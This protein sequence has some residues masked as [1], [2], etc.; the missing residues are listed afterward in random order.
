M[1]EE[2]AAGSGNEVQDVVDKEGGL[3]TYQRMRERV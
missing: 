3:F 1:A 2:T